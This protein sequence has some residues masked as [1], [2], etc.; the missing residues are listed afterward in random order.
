MSPGFHEKQGQSCCLPACLPSYLCVW[1]NYSYSQCGTTCVHNKEMKCWRLPRTSQDTGHICKSLTNISNASR[2]DTFPAER[3]S[4]EKWHTGFKH[5][6]M[7]LPLRCM[8]DSDHIDK[9]TDQD[10]QSVTLSAHLKLSCTNPRGSTDT[11]AT[12]SGFLFV[13]SEVGM[14]SRVSQNRLEIVMWAPYWR[15]TARRID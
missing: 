2:S 3:Q 15:L 7:V 5:P 4:I 8:L 1:R 12:L 10:T 14:A 11:H 9:R 6:E 13:V